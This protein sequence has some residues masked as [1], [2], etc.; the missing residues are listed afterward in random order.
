MKRERRLFKCALAAMIAT[1]ALC[2]WAGDGPN[3]AILLFFGI[4]N[5]GWP[6]LWQKEP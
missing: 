5:L 2:A 4:A 3:A 6:F 1:G